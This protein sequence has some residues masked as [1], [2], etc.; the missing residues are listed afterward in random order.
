MV[1]GFFFFYH[2]LSLN[3]LVFF[4]KKTKKYIDKLK[5]YSIEG[6]AKK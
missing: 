4:N 2:N 1:I 6:R 5:G 3:Y